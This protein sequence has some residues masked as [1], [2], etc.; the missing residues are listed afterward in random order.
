MVRLW[1]VYDIIRFGWCVTL[2]QG[3]IYQRMGSLG[4][5]PEHGAESSRGGIPLGALGAS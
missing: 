5:T 2:K 1:R 4:P 3:N